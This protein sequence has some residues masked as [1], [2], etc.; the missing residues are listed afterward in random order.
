MGGLW[1]VITIIG[2]IFLMAALIYAMVRNGVGSRAQIE[3]AERGAVQLREE[4][5]KDSDYSD[6]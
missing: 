1:G 6:E 3:K 4:I 5:R 2:P